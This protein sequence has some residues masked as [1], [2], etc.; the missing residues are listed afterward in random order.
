METRF[1]NENLCDEKD[2]NENIKQKNFLL[3][4]TNHYTTVAGGQGINYRN[5]GNL[6]L[7]DDD[8]A[9]KHSCQRT[10]DGFKICCHTPSRGCNW[11]SPDTWDGLQSL[12]GEL[13]PVC[14]CPRGSQ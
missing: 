5:V 3:L 2:D 4:G 1:K 10:L 7:I 8:N 6:D 11:H 14:Q 13:H 9:P 12:D